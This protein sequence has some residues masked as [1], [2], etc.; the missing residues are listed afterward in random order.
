MLRILKASTITARDSL[1]ARHRAGDEERSARDPWP[2][3]SLEARGSRDV[4]AAAPRGVETTRGHGWERVLEDV[5]GGDEAMN[6]VG[7]RVLEELSE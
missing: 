6:S 1:R 5:H 2:V 7:V 4:S 3:H